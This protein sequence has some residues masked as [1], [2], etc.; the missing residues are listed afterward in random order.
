MLKDTVTIKVKA[1]DGGEGSPQVYGTRSIGG[2]GGDG[3]NIILKGTTSK[4][5]LSTISPTKL[6]KAKDGTHGN[7]TSKKGARGSDLIIEVPLVT[8]VYDG[9]EFLFKISKRDQEEILQEGGDGGIGSISQGLQEALRKSYEQVQEVEEHSF[10]LVMKVHS[11]AIFLGLPNAGKSSM[12]NVLAH[13]AVKT[14]S[15]SFT[16]L[17]PQTGVLDG[18][19]LMDLP[20][21]IEGTADGKGVGVDFIKHTESARLIV[22]FVSCEEIDPI[23]NYKLIRSEIETLPEHVRS[24]KEIIVLTKYDSVSEQRR[25]ELMKSLSKFNSDITYSSIIDDDTVE[26]VKK[27][28][29][30]NLK[31]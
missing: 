15:Y 20:G 24:M 17:A 29:L 18:Y 2:D 11:D 12:L 7:T 28:I 3:G 23:A 30:D 19:T 31:D 26:N 27:L 9:D 5:S 10:K 14:A 13:T 21:L 6:Y 22:H 1:G 4:R 25:D 16:T 8:E